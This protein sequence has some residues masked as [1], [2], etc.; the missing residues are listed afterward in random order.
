M[1]AGVYNIF[2]RKYDDPGGTEHQPALD[3]LRQN[4]RNFR[5]KITYAF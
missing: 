4:G 1:R 5:F 3:A 2:N